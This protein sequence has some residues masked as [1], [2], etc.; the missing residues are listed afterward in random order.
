MWISIGLH[1]VMGLGC[2]G[3]GSSGT[4]PTGD[5]GTGGQLSSCRHRICWRG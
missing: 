3:G 1:L 5:T 4:G 2:L